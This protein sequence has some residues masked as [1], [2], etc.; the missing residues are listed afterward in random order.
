LIAA[1]HFKRK[2]GL[3]ILFDGQYELSDN[4]L[5]KDCL[6]DL[7]KISVLPAAEVENKRKKKQKKKKG[8]A[9]DPNFSFNV[10]QE[11]VDLP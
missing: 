4:F 2:T 11:K 9:I 1:D 8:A 10:I 5:V 7:S 3:K 6:T